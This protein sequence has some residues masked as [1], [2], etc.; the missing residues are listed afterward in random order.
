MIRSR[1]ELLHP[2]GDGVTEVGFALLAEQALSDIADLQ[3]LVVKLARIILQVGLHVLQQLVDING[4]CGYFDIRAIAEAEPE[5]GFGPGGEDIGLLELAPGFDDLV[6][7]L[8]LGFTGAFVIKPVQIEAQH[9]GG[10]RI[11]AAI[12]I[13][14]CQAGERAFGIG[15]AGGAGTGGRIGGTG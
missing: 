4:A 14:I 9:G 2:F 5:F 1:L 11:L 6:E 13:D 7:L 12:G 15:L 10:T 3:F 8:L